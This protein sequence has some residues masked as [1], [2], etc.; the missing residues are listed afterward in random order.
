MG[1]SKDLVT[2]VWM[3]G[4][5]AVIHWRSLDLGEGAKTALPV[6][7]RYMEKVYSDKSLG[8]T[9]GYFP[10]PKVAIRKAY[11]CI[12]VIPRRVVVSLDSLRLDGS[13]DLPASETDSL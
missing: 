11:R 5:D 1:L 12:T 3:G 4:D 6:Y 9:M 2:G 13:G 8:I 10:K 7:G